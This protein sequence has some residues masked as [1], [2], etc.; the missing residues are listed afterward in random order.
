MSAV[1]D[2]LNL[3]QNDIGG[4]FDNVCSNVH[5]MREMLGL[6]GN[7]DGSGHFDIIG[8]NAFLHMNKA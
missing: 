3:G 8:T 6:V 5:D 7:A 2:C 4:K 1:S